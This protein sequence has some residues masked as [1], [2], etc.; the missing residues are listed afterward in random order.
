MHIICSSNSPLKG[1][2]GHAKLSGKRFHCITQL[3]STVL[4]NLDTTGTEKIVHYGG[5]ALIQGFFS[6]A[7]V[8]N[9]TT[10]DVLYREV[11]LFQGCPEGSPLYIPTPKQSQQLHKPIIMVAF[12]GG[13][14]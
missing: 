11:S 13:V 2:N 9:G 4:Y 5:A 1:D 10:E 12:W 14:T 7:S 3:M 8:V 6:T